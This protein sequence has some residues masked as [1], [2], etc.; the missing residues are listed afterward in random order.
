MGN[1]FSWDLYLCILDRDIKIRRLMKYY[2]KRVELKKVFLYF[3]PKITK[4][5]IK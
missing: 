4:V 3:K 1:M 2:K 5:L